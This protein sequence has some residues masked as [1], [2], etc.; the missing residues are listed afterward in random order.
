[1]QGPQARDAARHAGREVAG[2]RPIRHRS[3]FVE[4]HVPTGS[5]G[6][7]FAKIE[8][9]RL[10]VDRHDGEP[11]AADIARRRQRHRKRER[12]G[13]GGID[14]GAAV[15]QHGRADAAGERRVGHDDSVRSGDIRH[16]ERMRPGGRHRRR[17]NAR[18]S[19]RSA[20]AA[21]DHDSSEE[22]ERT[23]VAVIARIVSSAPT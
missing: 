12:R 7:G 2:D 10:S 19:I 23:L 5:G 4:K 18:G 13:D 15:A 16:A 20:A 6:C 11:T 17:R 8:R 1:M 9:P 21:A 14:G 22:N 3:V